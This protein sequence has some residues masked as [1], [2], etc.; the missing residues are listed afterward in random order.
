MSLPEISASEAAALLAEHPEKHVL[1]DVREPVELEMARLDP[2]V[3]IPMG[4]I[5]ARL[6]ELDRSKTIICMCRVG[7]R[8][9]QVGEFL[10]QQGFT[11]V[12][13]LAG[14]INAWSDEVDDSIPLY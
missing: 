7:G 2:S 3:H 11:S 8:S 13:N 14:G 4:E 10:L 6:T 12:V 5:P 9:A 1:L